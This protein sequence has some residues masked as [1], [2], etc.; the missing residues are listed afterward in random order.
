M[1]PSL[2]LQHLIEKKDLAGT[3]MSE[4]MRMMMAGELQP[5]MVAALLVALRSKQETASEIAAAAQVM[6][7]FAT[8]VEVNDKSHLVDVVGTGGDG[9]HTFNISTASMLVAAAGGAKIAKHGNRSVSSKSGS[10]D[11]LEAFG[12]KLNLSA[13]A[14][15][16]CIEKTGLGFMFAPNHHPAMKNVVPV[17]KDLGVRTVFNILGPLTNPAKAPHILMG[18]FNADLVRIQAEVLKLLGTQSALVVYGRDGLDEISLQGPSLVGELKSGLVS[19]YEI[20]PE[21]FGFDVAPTSLLKVSD[22]N[23][24]KEIIWAVL[25]NQSGPA[26]DIV[27]LNA[28]ATLYVSGISENIK[29]GVQIAKDAITSGAAKQKLNDFVACTQALAPIN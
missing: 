15:S 23:E 26:K 27:C 2:V 13:Q 17:R 29:Q 3:D 14:V 11:V 12:V 7:N 8:A 24:S 25:N 20:K 19:E 10:A 22:A 21:D 5:T 9:A 4:L 6:R 18:V 28:G 1:N 16:Q